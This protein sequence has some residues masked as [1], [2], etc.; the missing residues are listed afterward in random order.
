MEGEDEYES[1]LDKPG[2]PR[3]DLSGAG[4]EISPKFLPVLTGLSSPLS[5]EL[6]SLKDEEDDCRPLKWGGTYLELVGAG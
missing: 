6:V 5:K 2:R 3:E 4:E 1:S